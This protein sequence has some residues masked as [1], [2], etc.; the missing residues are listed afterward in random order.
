LICS[1]VS[2]KKVIRR[3]G[4]FDTIV[5]KARSGKNANP[6][7]I[8]KLK[9]ISMPLVSIGFCEVLLPVA[10]DLCFVIILGVILSARI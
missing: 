8:H 1:I 9:G 2:P 10:E 6:V 5:K 4:E 7:T 3:P